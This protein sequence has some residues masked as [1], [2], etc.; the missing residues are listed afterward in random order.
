[1][2]TSSILII[3]SFVVDQAQAVCRAAAF[4]GGGARGAYEAGVVYG[5]NHAKNPEDFAWDVVTGVS[6]GALNSAGISLWP[7][8]EGVKMSEW[9][10]SV[11]SNLTTDMV[12]QSWPLGWLDGIT[13]ESGLYDNTP[14]LNLMTKIYNTFGQVKRKAVVSSVDVNTG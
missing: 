2:I 5:L 1:M 14:L 7:P 11:W 9:L 3:S 8:N 6:A 12:Y 10:I 4:A 13:S